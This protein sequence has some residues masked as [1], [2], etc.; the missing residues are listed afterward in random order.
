MRFPIGDKLLALKEEGRIPFHMP[1]HKRKNNI[2]TDDR[3]IEISTRETDLQDISIQEKNRQERDTQM[4]GIQA[5]NYMDITEI[6]DYDNLHHPEGIILESMNMVKEIYHTKKSWYLVNGST[7]GILSAI[8]AVCSPGDGIIISRNC[9]KAVYNAVRL[10]HLRPYYIYPSYSEKYDMLQ[11][12]DAKERQEIGKILEDHSDIKAVVVTSPTYEGLVSDIR[13]IKHVLEPYQVPLI[14]DEAHGAHFTFHEYFPKSAV[15][16]GADL[17]IQSAHKTLPSFTQTALLHLCS[18]LVAEE[19]VEEMLSIYQTSSPSYL[20]MAS[21]EF[22]VLYTQNHPDKVQSYVDKLIDFRRKCAQLQK[23][24]LLEPSDVQG[25]DYDQGKLVFVVK[26]SGMDGKEFFDR[27]LNQY[28]IELEMETAFYGIAMTSI[29]DDENDFQALWDA[30]YDMDCQLAAVTPD[31]I[32][33]DDE[34]EL[35]QKLNNKKV[36]EKQT[37]DTSSVEQEDYLQA[38]LFSERPERQYYAWEMKNLPKERIP[39]E[40][41]EGRI[42]SEYLYLYPPGIPILVPGEKITKEIVVNMNYYLYN[43]YNVPAL[44]DGKIE[45]LS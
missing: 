4:A 16:C 20:L 27:L 35:D 6:S 26:E 40:E 14:V 9:H 1:G 39:F 24:H 30:V 5:L 42:V 17:V 8:S 10:L 45:V 32:K 7:C 19:A 18:D 31:S 41:S 37:L 11:G 2:K 15:E 3:N 33:T 34:K 13:A 12:I 21:A 44:S 43:G 22:G 28:H 36:E 23:I 25:F 29:N 38:S